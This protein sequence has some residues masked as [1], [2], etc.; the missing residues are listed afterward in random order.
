MNPLLQKAQKILE[1][2]NL[3][4]S[5]VATLGE[6]HFYICV[7]MDKADNIRNA[8]RFKQNLGFYL[9]LSFVLSNSFFS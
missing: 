4:G 5:L 1:E 7:N 9:L 2:S 8:F 6:I 3:K